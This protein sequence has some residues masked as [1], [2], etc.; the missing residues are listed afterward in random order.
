M[1]VT[2]L[3]AVMVKEAPKALVT[4]PEINIGADAAKK[5]SVYPMRHRIML[6]W[7]MSLSLVVAATFILFVRNSDMEGKRMK[8]TDRLTMR[9]RDGRYDVCQWTLLDL[10]LFDGMGVTIPDQSSR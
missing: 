10:S 4:K 2:K 3:R 7:V 6:T 1:D 9:R 8:N 5:I